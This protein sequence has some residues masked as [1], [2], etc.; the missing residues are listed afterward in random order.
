MARFAFG[1]RA[2]LDS[3]RIQ[4]RGSVARVATSPFYSEAE[5]TF[6]RAQDW[7]AGGADSLSLYFQGS[8]TNS[9]QTLC[10]MLE[11]N[12]GHAATVSHANPDAV[13]AAEWQQW[14]IPL[15]QFAG[16]N[17]SRIQKIVVGIGSRTSPTA[18]GTGIVYVDDIGYG[19][20]ASAD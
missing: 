4:P 2:G 17:P 15:D 13:L 5:R 9:P 14:R 19:R 3:I 20:P 16:I 12:A 10:L 6:D 1:R 11:D 7:T 8:P 18:G